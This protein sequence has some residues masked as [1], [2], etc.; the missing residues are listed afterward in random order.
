MIKL[1]SLRQ[2]IVFLLLVLLVLLLKLPVL[3]LDNPI[4]GDY[5]S[6]TFFGDLFVFLNQTKLTSYLA[7][8]TI[9]IVQTLHLNYIFE[10]HAVHLK[11]TFL[12]AFFYILFACLLTKVDANIT[13]SL[14]VQTPLMFAL[15]IY[16][17]LYKSNAVKE[18]VFTAMFIVGIGILLYLP[19]AYLLLGF[20]ICLFFIKIPSLRD[21]MIATISALLPVYF[22]LVYS[23]YTNNVL[24]F[25]EK[26]KLL[27]LFTSSF[28]FE[29]TQAELTLLAAIGMIVLVASMKLY[30]NHFKNIIKTRIIQE[31]LFVLSFIILLVLIFLLK[32]QY[33]H[34][35][36]FLIP[37]SYILSYFMMGKW[38]FFLNEILTVVL[39]LSI[40]LLKFYPL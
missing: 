39:F 7:G 35:L 32:F 28:K 12:P 17:D 10:K 29:E 5:T 22:A 14:L 20:W 4:K 18:K 2:P 34:L 33:Q 24:Y 37:F 38:K 21:F 8:S 1:F 23:Y 11:N 36:F 15:E 27:I 31:M 19:L 26:F 30:S 3:L 40:I 13:P 9:I 25:V 16:F 6:Y